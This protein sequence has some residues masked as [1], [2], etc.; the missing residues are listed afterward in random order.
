M[1]ERTPARLWPIQATWLRQPPHA[2]FWQGFAAR[3][4]LAH[5]KRTALH[6][7]A[8][9]VR[10]DHSSARMAPA[11]RT[12]RLVIEPLVP[13]G[14]SPRLLPR[15]TSLASRLL[16]R[17]TPTRLIQ[18]V[19]QHVLRIARR[20][21]V[22]QQGLQ[23]RLTGTQPQQHGFRANADKSDNRRPRSRLG[24]PASVDQTNGRSSAP[25]TPAS[26]P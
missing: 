19:L 9:V 4:R 23:L 26:A 11:D 8:S 1:H 7:G 16:P 20:P 15:P 25:A 18:P 17:R 5:G 21:P 12:P 6:D 24:N 10:G 22:R 3:P 14:R 2:V 13:T